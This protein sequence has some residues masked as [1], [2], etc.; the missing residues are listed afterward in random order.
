M[1]VPPTVSDENGWS[2]NYHT[3]DKGP[4]LATPDGEQR[5]PVV[6]DSPFVVAKWFE[7]S[8]LDWSL[9]VY[10]WEADSPVCRYKD[11]DLYSFK[12]RI[13]SKC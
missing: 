2:E 8:N 4:L 6:K 9:P 10:L 7:S 13:H 3:Q 11:P 1:K 12:N 5:P